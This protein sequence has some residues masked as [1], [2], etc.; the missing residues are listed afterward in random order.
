MSY[1]AEAAK[2]EIEGWAIFLVLFYRLPEFLELI[3]PLSL[4][5]GFLLAYG[6]MYV[7]YE[8]V[9]LKAC[10]M[11]QWRL[12]YLS[13]APALFTALLVA[14]MSLF[15]VP[16]GF[17]N[18][19]K[20]LTLQYDRSPLELLTPGKFS[21]SDNGDVIYAE[22]INSDKNQITGFFSSKKTENHFVT[23]VAETGLRELDA[24]TGAQ[25]M[26]L[27]N[28]RRYELDKDSAKV[29]EVKFETY[30]FKLKEPDQNKMRNR[31]Q[32]TPTQD[33]LGSKDKQEQAELQW[34][35]TVA[36]MSLILVLLAVPLSKV[37]PRQGRF[38]KLI[39]AILL[40]LI[41]VGMILVVKNKIAEGVIDAFPGIWLVHF[42]F[43]FLALVLLEG[44]SIKNIFS[45]SKQ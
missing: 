2:G 40:Y 13:S 23:I 37:N 8:M 41:Y 16:Q 1:M 15:L 36:P 7:E 11:S 27:K 28:G 6:R 10:G 33:L 38:L 34:R 22:S 5:L 12:V 29:N 39:P 43:F 19:N 31:L 42:L 25:F 17:L 32:S 21:T 20:I 14:Y 3:L 26:L 35:L 4:F 9:V 45:F 18:Y 30:K 24:E 44:E